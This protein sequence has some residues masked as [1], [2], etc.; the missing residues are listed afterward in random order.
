MIEKEK[1]K[2][3]FSYKN[4]EEKKRNFFFFF[5]KK[6]RGYSHPENIVGMVQV[7]L[8]GTKRG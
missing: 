2:E 1:E 3:N 5:M 6:R 8:V 4:K 7:L